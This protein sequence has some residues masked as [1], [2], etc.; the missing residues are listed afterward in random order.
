[1][2]LGSSPGSNPYSERFF[3]SY[4]IFQHFQKTNTCKFQFY[5]HFQTRSWKLLS[6]YWVND[7]YVPFTIWSFQRTG[8]KKIVR[9][10]PGLGQG[11][12]RVRKNPVI[13]CIELKVLHLLRDTVQVLSGV[14]CICSLK[15]QLG[16]DLNIFPVLP[17]MTEDQWP[18][19]LGKT[20]SSNERGETEIEADK[21]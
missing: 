1:M 5:S 15:I 13:Q 11:N 4:F 7:Y 8:R 2:S 12:A 17:H 19:E 16:W 9:S 20:V 10:F 6:V 3:C 21:I 14:K 18:H